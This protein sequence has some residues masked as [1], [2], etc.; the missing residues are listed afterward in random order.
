MCGDCKIIFYAW[1]KAIKTCLIVIFCNYIHS[2]QSH[3]KCTYGN[4][5]WKTVHRTALDCMK[6][7]LKIT[8]IS[9]ENDNFLCAVIDLI[10]SNCLRWVVFLARSTELI[11]RSFFLTLSASCGVFVSVRLKSEAFARFFSQLDVKS[12]AA[13][14]V[15]YHVLWKKYLILWF[16]F[17]ILVK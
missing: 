3:F 15:S 16:F 9:L 13:L 11:C 1:C 4:K 10:K 7:N 5:K 6:S 14:T 17:I 2:Q 12:F 8:Y